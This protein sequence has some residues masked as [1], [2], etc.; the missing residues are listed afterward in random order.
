MLSSLL[1]KHKNN[2]FKKKSFHKKNYFN[3]KYLFNNKKSKN[4]KLKIKDS[5]NN[6]GN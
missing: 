3:K 6:Q 5:N 4:Y 1:F 2:N